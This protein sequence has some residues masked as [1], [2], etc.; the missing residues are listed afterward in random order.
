MYIHIY[1]HYIYIYTHIYTCIYIC[2]CAEALTF[3]VM[4][5]RDGAFGSRQVMRGAH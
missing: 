2:P 4:G 3:N 5:F 1:T